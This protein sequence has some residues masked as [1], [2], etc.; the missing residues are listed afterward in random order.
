MSAPS[1]SLRFPGL[2]E[3]ED[4]RT[5]AARAR[6]ADDDGAMRL[7]ARGTTLAAY[8]GVI[9]GVGLMGEG[10]VLGLRTM[11][12]AEPAEVDITV[13][14]ASLADRLARPS[15]DAVLPLPPM[16]LST[17]WAALSPPRS[18]WERVGTLT[19]EE[20]DEVAAQ[21][22]REIATGAPGDAGGHAVTALR[23][24]VWGRAAP[25]VP[26]IPAGGAFAAYALGFA[27]AGTEAIAFAHG[28]WTRLTCSGGHVLMR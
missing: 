14:L 2:P 10:L 23:Q 4:L 21:G 1:V 12:L 20:L 8:V 13:S 25:T 6:V 15:A 19:A 28:R 9:D 22:V 27:P 26:P 24:R 5:Y 16:T 3:L 7:Q 17:A 18:G 11:A